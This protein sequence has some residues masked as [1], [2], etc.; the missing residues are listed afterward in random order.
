MSNALNQ[1]RLINVL[2][3]PHVSEKTSNVS[4]KNNQV[5]FKVRVD[6]TKAEIKKA[7]E[8]MF[9]VK[10]EGVQVTNMKGKAKRFGQTKGRRKDW[11]KAY[12]TL[13]EGQD[14]DFIG[15]E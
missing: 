1:E 9:E 14:I 8:L 11:K 6:S 3:G 7:V 13:A 10:V 12:V 2:V 5:A 15:A 4:D